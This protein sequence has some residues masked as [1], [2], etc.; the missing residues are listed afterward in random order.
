MLDYIENY[1]FILKYLV[2]KTTARRISHKHF[3]TPY[4]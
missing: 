2:V 4:P 1:N 3:F